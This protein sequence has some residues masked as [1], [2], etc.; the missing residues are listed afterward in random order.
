MDFFIGVLLM[1]F[2]DRD[3]TQTKYDPHAFDIDD[4]GDSRPEFITKDYENIQDMF[5][6]IKEHYA[7][8][9]NEW[10]QRKYKNIRKYND[11]GDDE[12]IIFE[13]F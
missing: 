6:D 1:L 2:C 3:K 11:S 9:E 10:N 4:Y 13:D 12:Y 8:K 5:K 7:K